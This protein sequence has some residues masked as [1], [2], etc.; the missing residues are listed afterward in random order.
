MF[1]N[2][3]T[4]DE[5]LIVSQSVNEKKYW[6][7]KLSG[8]LEK[9]S[10]SYDFD[11]KVTGDKKNDEKR[12]FQLMKFKITGE[13]YAKLRWITNNS[14]VQLHMLLVALLVSL[15][16]KYNYNR[17]NEFT[18]GT[19]IYKQDTEGDFINTLLI[20]RNHLKDQMTFKKLL[21]QVRQT[22]KEAVEN[23]NYPINAILSDL[24]ISFDERSDDFPLFDVA[25]LL[26]NIQSRNYIRDIK[27]NMIFSFSRTDESLEGTVEYN[28]VRYGKVTIKRIID[29]FVRLIPGV[30]LN[31]DSELS[32]IDILS[33]DE[34][35]QILVDFNNTRVPHRQAKTIHALFEE[36]VEKIPDK[37]AVVFKDCRLTYKEL[38]NRANQLARH[39]RRNGVK[40]RTIVGIM[41][42]HSLE[43]I[44]GILGILKAGSA[45]LPIDTKVPLK[46]VISML[47]DCSISFLITGKDAHEKNSFTSLQNLKVKRVKPFLT[48]V[49]PQ[50]PDLDQL[51]IPDRSL[52]NYEK[53]DPYI[54]QANVKYAISL[55]AS[56]GCPYRCVYCHK[57]WPKTHIFRSA[58]HIYA[59]VQRYYEMGVRR[60]AFIDDIFNLD[61]KNSS[62]FFELILKNNLDVHFFFPNGVRGDI[63]TK[64]YIDLS[65]EAGTVEM[66]FA[67]ETA[68]PRL[69]KLI[70]KN[71]NLKKFQQNLE[72]ITKKY[73]HVVLDLFTMHGFP[74]E[75]KEEAMKTLDFIKSMKWLHF[76]YIF[77]LKVY[78]NTDMEELALNNG[79][80]PE[81][82][83]VSENLAYHQLPETL[84]FEKSFTLQYQSDF[85]YNYFLC[86]ERILH[87]LPYQMKIMNEDEIVKKWNGYL[88][89]PIQTFAQ[90]LEFLEV[91]E[92]ELEVSG[93]RPNS[94]RYAPGLYR[95]MKA[96]FPQIEPDEDALRVLMLDVTH[97]FSD[98]DDVFADATE[99]PL[100][101]MYLLSYLNWRWGKKVKGKIAKSRIDFDSYGQ[102]KKLL[103]DFNPDVI[104]IRA[105]SHYKDFFHET[106]SVIR[107]SGITAPIIAGGPYATSS[108]ITL[109]QDKNV[110]LVVLGEGELTFSE[111]IQ[112]IMENDRQLPGDDVLKQIAGIVFVPQKA[113]I[114]EQFA[115]QIIRL[116][117]LNRIGNE[118]FVENLQ[119]INQWFDPAYVIY[120]SGSTGEPKGVMVEHRNVSHLVKNTNYIDLREGE[121]LLLTG[122]FGFDITTFEFWGPLLNGLSLYLVDKNVILD[123]EELKNV[124][125]KNR[126]S[127][128]HLIPQLFNQVTDQ[129]PGIFAGLKYLLV[130]GD[131]VSP[132]YINRVRNKYRD[133]KILHMYGPTEN[134]TFSTFFPVN[135]NYEGSI[136][137]GKPIGNTAVYV[138]DGSNQLQPIGAAGELC[139]T[140]HGLARGYINQPELTKEKFIPNPFAFHPLV[141]DGYEPMEIIYKTGDL[142]R[143]LPGGNIE[144]IGRNDHQIKIRGF[145]LELG[146]VENVLRKHKGIEECAAVCR[147]VK[148]ENQLIAYYKKK[149]KIELWPS[150]AEYFAYD[151]LLYHAIA[152]DEARNEKYRNAIAKA[153]KDKVVLEIGPGNEAILSR[154]CI[155]A[156]AKKVY[157]VEILES[158]YKRAR[159]TVKKL[160][161]EDKIILIHG[162]ITAVKLPVKVD[163]CVSEIVGTIGG[164]EGAAAIINSAR[165]HLKVPTCMI[166]SRSVTKIAAITLPAGEFDETFEE[167]GASYVEKIFDHIKR[168]FDLRL[169]LLNFPQK[170]VISS[171]DVFEDL[172]FTRENELEGEHDIY[173]EIVTPS[174][175]NGF[176]V[177]L[178]LFCDDREVINTL[179]KKYIWLPIYFPVFSEGIP[180][181]KGD[182]I[183]AKVIRKL[184]EN[185]LNPDFTLEGTL[186]KKQKNQCIDFVFH[187]PHLSPEFKGNRFY[188]QIFSKDKIKVTRN[189][190]PG[191]IRESLTHE[192]PDYMIPS[193]LVEL[194]AFPLTTSGKIN[195]NA[196]PNPEIESIEGYVA[197]QDDMEEKLCEICAKE[198]GID[199]KSMGIDSNFFDIGGHSL[200]ITRIAAKLH[201]EFEIKVS[202]KEIFD[203]PTIR[204]LSKYIKTTVK[205][206]FLAIPSAEKKEYYP[207]SSAQSGI[208]YFWQLEKESIAYNLSN[209]VELHGNI[210]R[211][212]INEILKNLIN[213]HEIMRTSFHLINGEPVQR[214]HHQVEF[215]IEYYDIKGEG[216]EAEVKR[217]QETLIKS[218]MRP[219]D[220]SHIPLFRFG[221]IAVEE[222]K[223]IFM[224]EKHHIITDQTSFELFWHE[225]IRLNREEE[226]PPLYIQYK[227]YSEWQ[228]TKEEREKLE[229]QE[230]FWL[231]QFKGEIPILN[232]PTDYEKSPVQTI[233][234]AS[235][236]FEIGGVET[237]A[238]R[239]MAAAEGATFFMILLS[240]VY[241]FL[242]KLTGQEDIVIV[243]P[244]AGRNHVE[245]HTLFG[246]FVNLISL[247]NYPNVDKPFTRFFREVKENTLQAFEN[248]DYQF[249]KLVKNVLH[250]R[251]IHLNPL[252]DIAFQ[253]IS[254][255][256][257]QQSE[258]QK[259]ENSQL[260]IKPYDIELNT[261][262]INFYIGVVDLGDQLSIKFEYNKRLFKSETIERFASYFKDI[263]S[264]VV[265]DKNVNLEDINISYRL[266]DQKIKNPQMDFS[267][268]L[269]N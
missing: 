236:S 163:Y 201:K 232:L 109:L 151:E 117:A 254:A 179:E 152:H 17:D 252:R 170:N 227:D 62:R 205:N 208:Y 265:K 30:L 74:S 3:I 84:P 42:D 16:Y 153:V 258:T 138:V 24:N 72:Y 239:E 41:L 222:G 2:K 263:V 52:V 121:R 110:D 142:A 60:F 86:K 162:D 264:S 266:F 1:E 78:P 29:H 226:L 240:I 164:S 234:A 7:K 144:F 61:Q 108:Y 67:L 224:F 166:P 220:L 122:A 12:T 256:R 161:L 233:E 206:K 259:E 113:N 231:N 196:L 43:M 105:L 174:I 14:D 106:V 120:T 32:R 65:I 199:K 217:K 71:L 22:I 250:T 147:K 132:G 137:I 186:Y 244:T 4:M 54:S 116:D 134:T 157:A 66:A 268:Q 21:F 198:L 242:H 68:S 143:W 218:F 192:L 173:L 195:R 83:A 23:Q 75:T 114:K 168:K 124:I 145:R 210:N 146:E 127:I 69:Q 48:G 96:S 44:V 245:L 103:D 51:P 155:E 15:L 158:A 260:T 53:Y 190:T 129:Q 255:P 204:G 95:K 235:K 40:S 63:M 257:H 47:G 209:I 93:C 92:D 101:A 175:I 149:N 243:T 126:I 89:N 189:L 172:D 27:L 188:E 130:G 38:N 207:L 88:P 148:G 112:K 57:V 34:K 90:L 102:L 25:L 214:I 139:V 115:P 91:R 8:N 182:Y 187:S 178:H 5:A 119:S 241:V 59:E 213:V 125:V 45:Y 177:W 169:S 39:L 46:R 267:F 133:L 238:F 35:K 11:K 55:Q 197:P 58:E 64:E 140:G 10:F 262:K 160:K 183:K 215:E 136:P 200:I 184:S 135:E 33:V 94:Y 49:R 76:P 107:Q 223:Y 37:T 31:L 212:K 150:M 154:M 219:F 104:G 171:P 216:T 194:D 191:D 6:L 237:R 203:E 181:Q 87:I 176:I 9:S 28:P 97:F 211:D 118:E 70:K 111:I 18:I 249:E 19:T 56:R 251:D 230:E 185:N 261:F 229:K 85:L 159:E 221:I 228:N 165:N 193:F 123:A 247:R 253:L 98:N 13:I 26:T 50:I 269:T 248:Q 80:T 79:V 128:L 73:P 81:S 167:I 180:V 100:G 246:L 225:L 131:V 36:Q 141:P 202:I 20:L 82:I 156:G 77:I 99:P